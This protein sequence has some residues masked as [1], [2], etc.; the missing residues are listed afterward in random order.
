MFKIGT[1]VRLN[2]E[3]IK[4]YSDNY[5]INK[6]EGQHEVIFRIHLMDGNAVIIENVK[7]KEKQLINKTNLIPISFKEVFNELKGGTNV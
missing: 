2:P 6:Y 7:T 4:W 1:L 5:V 3:Y